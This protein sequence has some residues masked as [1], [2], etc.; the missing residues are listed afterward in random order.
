MSGSTFPPLV[1]TWMVCKLII[2]C[3]R[4]ADTLASPA[5]VWAVL[6][7]LAV[8]CEIF[9]KSSTFWT[10]SPIAISTYSDFLN[11]SKAA[12]IISV[13]LVEV[14]SCLISCGITAPS[15][16]VI[17]MCVLATAPVLSYCGYFPVTFQLRIIILLYFLQIVPKYYQLRR[18]PLM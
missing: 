1:N 11:S 6:A 8:S 10:A 18:F 5:A 9:S 17:M 7:V 16:A 4:S 2:R 3:V 15:S 12:L 14:K 13:S